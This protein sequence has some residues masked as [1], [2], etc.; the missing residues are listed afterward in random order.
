GEYFSM[1][2][3]N[4]WFPQSLSERAAW[5][6]NFATQFSDLATGLGFLP[7]DVTA[8][9]S[10]NITLQALATWTVG[11][12]AYSKAATA[13]RKEITQGDVGSPAPVLP[14]SPDFP[15]ITIALPGLY[16]RLD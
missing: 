12:E 15:D 5:Y 4:T 6:Q 3:S 8:V 10:D 14:D 13:F 11:V 1:I 16:E 2:P 7:A 9:D